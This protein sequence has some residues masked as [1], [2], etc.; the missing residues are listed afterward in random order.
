MSLGKWLALAGTAA[1]VLAFPVA[2]SHEIDSP[3]VSTAA[4]LVPDLA[5][6]EQLTTKVTIRGSGFTPMPSKAVEG[7]EQL[8]LP[9]VELSR[10]KL[11]DGSTSSDAAVGVPDDPS[12]PIASHV[13]W[14][15]SSEMAF[16]VFPELKLATGVYDVTV[17]NPDGVQVAS[18]RGSFGALP[19]PSAK[20][21]VPPAIC[22]DQSDQ[23][24]TIQGANFLQIGAELPTVSVGGKL[25][26]ADSV[27]GCTPVP[28]TFTEGNVQLC[29][30]LT[31]TVPKGTLTPGDYPITV[32][33]PAPA[34]CV[35]SETLSLRDNPPP[36]VTKVTPATICEGGGKLAIDG[37]DFIATPGVTLVSQGEPTV[38]A[39]SVTIQGTTH[40]D[41][42]F[43]GGATVGKTYD[44]VVTNPDGCS[45]LP[46]HKQV[47]VKPGPIVYYADPEVVYN[48]VAMRVTVYVTAAYSPS[49]IVTMVPSGQS[50][51]ITTLVTSPVAGHPNRFQ[52]V[53][54][55]GQAAGSYDLILDDGSG[56][57]AT[58]PN[59]I[60]VTQQLTITLKTPPNGMVPSFGWT[61]S[62]TAVTIFRDT[63]APP[64]G[65]VK[66]VATPR[67]FLNPTN[68][69]PN[70]VAIALP[71]VAF[72]DADTLTAVVPKG[73][74]ARDYDLIVTDPD[75][76]V[77]FLA[78]AFTVVANAPPVI[79]A[80]VPSSIVAASGQNITLKG[81]DFRAGA[82]V[83][84]A[85]KDKNAAT[86]TPPTVTGAITCNSGACTAA[87][88]VDASGL[89]G[90]VVP[91]CIVRITNTDGTWGEYSAVGVTNASLNLEKPPIAGTTMNVA[92]RALVAS[93]VDAT[94]SA[95]FVYA[96]G[97]D[98]G[99]AGQANPFNSS[100]LASVDLYGKLG[101]WVQQR[102]DIGGARSFAAGTRSGRYTYVYGGW[103]GTNALATARRGMT[104]S[105]RETPALDVDD[106]VL[107]TNGLDAGYWMYRVSATFSNADLDNPGG[108][109]LTSDEFIVKLPSFAGKKVQVKLSW[110][111]PRDALAVPLPNV[112]GYRIYRTE[113]V[114]G[115]SG[116]EVLIGASPSTT[117]TDDGTGVPQTTETPLPLGS[118]G[119]WAVLPNL[120]TPRRGAAGALGT[121]PVTA[122]AR[123]AYAFFGLD[124]AGV[125]SKTYEYLPITVLANGHETV[126]NA[127]KTGLSPTTTGRWQAGAWSMD[128]T[129]STT[130]TA[131]A[132]WI[133]VGGGQTAS[134]GAA[135]AV[136][137]GV[138]AAGGDLG[139][140]VAVKSFTAK[141]SGYG[142]C[143]ANGQ[144]FTLGGANG[145]PSSGGTAASLTNPAPTI[146]V[147]SWNS[148]GIQLVQPRYLMGSSVQS[149]F[150]FLVGGDVGGGVASNTTELI[151]W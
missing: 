138:V 81:T 72:V 22:D 78:K 129:N 80:V 121:D 5:C 68:P 10:V 97:G 13:H 20:Q 48:G 84:L 142:V 31:F 117:F 136:E 6:V 70:D 131:P 94:S 140:F 77:G 42:T 24:V 144:L 141:V 82:T 91:I 114:N 32:T 105:P 86:F 28:G 98:S 115:K 18:V 103:D 26:K 139:V 41:A 56:C 47:T 54:P 15:S 60:K 126:G 58:L 146:A 108:E 14:T 143:G 122:G 51:P 137:A 104:L 17:R 149:A 45:D 59:A 88:T 83:S 55:K 147:N 65:D 49:W 29:T 63:A 134:A 148:E 111:V 123:Y 19:P 66:F 44:V 62:E 39:G 21:L 43:P 16:D 9:R 128:A 85:C 151:I 89:T 125:E 107:G 12:N 33:N 34:N 118:M 46:P 132:N 90:A 95:R 145:G 119:K 25:F 127:W 27:S 112:T 73:Q 109:S 124:G 8:I 116:A 110:D 101:P 120:A 135:N 76:S 99:S 133:Y 40:L 130:I 50:S 23:K 75:G 4:P 11:L 69:G 150:I 3:P 7:P 2:C 96:I 37:T 57:L 30:S 52:A 87:A 74:T 53:I 36:T 1:L 79:T 106:L 92:R 113:K 102:Y 67:A 61:N 71:S 64:P 38:T 35:S 100:E 93:A